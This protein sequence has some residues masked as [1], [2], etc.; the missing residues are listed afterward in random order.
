MKKRSSNRFRMSCFSAAAAIL[1]ALAMAPAARAQHA[2]A[3]GHEASAVSPDQ[4]LEQ[5]MAG[6]ARFVAHAAKHPNQGAARMQELTGGQHPIA[7]VLSCSDS[8]VGPELVFDQGLGDV[9]VVRVAGNIADDA[10]IGSIEYA[11]EHLG[12]PLIVVMGHQKCG[13]VTAAMSGGEAGNHIH[14][15]VDP[16]MPVVAEA[17]KSAGDPVDAAI[18]LN[19]GRVVDQLEH[20]GPILAAKVGDNTLRIVG[21]Y[22]SLEGGKVTLLPGATEEHPATAKH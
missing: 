10:S 8:R 9:F 1:V 15:V 4:A 22:Y 7:V 13:A 19:V 11:V 17:K 3:A 5:L 2:E 6:N 14:A 18:R 12:A 21:A 16:I 20:T